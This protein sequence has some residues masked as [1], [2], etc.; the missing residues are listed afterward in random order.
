[1]RSS[2]RRRVVDLRMESKE[3]TLL[4]GQRPER[5]KTVVEKWLKG[6]AVRGSRILAML[7]PSSRH[8]PRIGF[9]IPAFG[10]MIIDQGS[11][12]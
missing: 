8:F 5:E 3:T 4:L 7:A 12:S 9:N 2:R 6:C 11:E 10:D 1:M